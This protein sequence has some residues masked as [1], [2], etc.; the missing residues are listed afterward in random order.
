MAAV[1]ILRSL[2]FRQAIEATKI[3][4][5]GDADPQIAKDATVRVDKLTMR[6]HLGGWAFAGGELLEGGMTFTEPSELTSTFRS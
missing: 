5:V 4:A 6:R 3:T 2:R 1:K